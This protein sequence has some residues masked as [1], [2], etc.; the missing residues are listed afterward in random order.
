M[1]SIVAYNLGQDAN[2]VRGE[3]NAQILPHL[4]SLGLI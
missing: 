3:N 2:Y 1:I 4:C